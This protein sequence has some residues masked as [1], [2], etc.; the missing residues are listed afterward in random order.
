MERFRVECSRVECRYL[1]KG[2]LE[3]DRTSCW[4]YV[5]V[6]PPF[7]EPGLRFRASSKGFKYQ[8]F[9]LLFLKNKSNYSLTPFSSTHEHPC[10]LFFSSLLLAFLLQLDPAWRFPKIGHS[11]QF[12]DFTTLKLETW[13]EGSWDFVTRKQGYKHGNGAYRQ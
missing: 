9:S 1:V 6:L 5:G 8:G 3:Q 13:L 11:S 12:V 2:L 4:D 10:K 7:S